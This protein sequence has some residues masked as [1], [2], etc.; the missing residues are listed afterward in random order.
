MRSGVNTDRSLASVVESCH[1]LH[2]GRGRSAVGSRVWTGGPGACP[3][4]RLA[5]QRII[6]LATRNLQSRQKEPQVH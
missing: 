1:S 6:Q 2:G 5:A 3:H 4:E